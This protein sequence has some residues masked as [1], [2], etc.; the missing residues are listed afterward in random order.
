M[1]PG[2]PGDAR[3]GDAVLSTWD[4]VIRA[5]KYLR[6]SSHAPVRL[7]KVSRIIGVSERGLRNAFYGVRGMSPT[8]YMRRERLNSVR[9]VLSERSQTPPT[10]TDVA[11][12]HGFYQLGHF[13][14]A[15]RK[16][17][18]EAPSDT[19]R[20]SLAAAARPQITANKDKQERLKR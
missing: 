3:R 10:V 9:R 8:Q 16:A 20:A 17:F 12:D 5:E 2:H 4:V 13:A 7:S 19:R 18:G 11:I 14:A 15:Y 1:Q 6:A